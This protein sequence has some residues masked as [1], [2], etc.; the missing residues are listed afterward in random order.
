M[1]KGNTIVQ[2]QPPPLSALPVPRRADNGSSL[3][4]IIKPKTWPNDNQNRYGT[5]TK[6]ARREGPA[7][8]IQIQ[9]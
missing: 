9:Q 1:K 2:S 3:F 4:C 8:E 7:K 6:P 5:E